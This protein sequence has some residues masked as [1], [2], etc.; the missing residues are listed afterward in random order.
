MVVVDDDVVVD[1]LAL[2]L[3]TK[4]K[5]LWGVGWERVARGEESE[6]NAMKK[7][8]IGGRCK[9]EFYSTKRTYHSRFISPNISVAS[10]YTLTY[11]PFIIDVA[12]AFCTTCSSFI[13]IV[14]VVVVWS[15]FPFDSVNP[16]L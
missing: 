15:L 10:K 4:P 6:L 3:V 8:C 11:S 13:I 16:N 9:V 5:Y 7:T 14:S 12:V 1:G 2:T